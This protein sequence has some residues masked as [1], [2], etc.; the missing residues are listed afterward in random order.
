MIRHQFWINPS[1]LISCALTSCNFGP[2]TIRGLWS[3]KHCVNKELHSAHIYIWSNLKPSLSKIRYRIKGIIQYHLLPS[4]HSCLPQHKARSQL[5]VQVL[6]LVIYLVSIMENHP[7]RCPTVILSATK[8]NLHHLPHWEIL[9]GPIVESHTT[10]S[11]IRS[12]SKTSQIGSKNPPAA[13][14]EVSLPQSSPMYSTMT[15]WL[16]LAIMIGSKMGSNFLEHPVRSTFFCGTR[17]I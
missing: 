9:M 10:S 15:I 3:T 11:H 12:G 6:S 8:P 1:S 17:S 2:C 7:P 4:T 13:Q 14:Y 5:H 16:H